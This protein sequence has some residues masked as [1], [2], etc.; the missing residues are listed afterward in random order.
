MTNE[1]KLLRL[2]GYASGIAGNDSGSGDGPYYLQNHQLIEIL[3]EG[4]LN[5]KWQNIISANSDKQLSKLKIVSDLCTKLAQETKKLAEQKQK[6]VVIGGDHSSAI[7][8]W[9]GAAA[10]YQAKGHIGLIWI[11]AHLDSHTP[12]SSETGNIHGMP[13]AC[14]LGYGAET[15]K[16]IAYSQA[17]ILPENLTIIGARSFEKAEQEL[18]KRLNIRVIYQDELNIMGVEAALIEAKKRAMNNAVAYGYSIDIDAID[19]NDAPGVG[20]PEENGI[21]SA[22]LLSALSQYA[23]DQNLIGLEIAEFNPHYDQQ[24]KTQKII[25]ELLLALT[26]RR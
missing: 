16:N 5:A 21:K 22:E 14:L 9:S 8:T 24:N 10:A 20:T 15:L 4:G 19:P 7:G 17:K 13:V 1:T 6:F 25:A 23:D 2:I 3:A 26:T 12:E 18:I 11:D